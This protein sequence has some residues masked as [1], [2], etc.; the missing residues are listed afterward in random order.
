MGVQT[1]FVHCSNA[2]QAVPQPPQFWTSL[3]RSTQAPE[4]VV[5]PGQHI[6]APPSGPPALAQPE[7]L[8]NP[9]DGTQ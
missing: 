6:D 2:E 3:V 5:K 4:H 8:P 9:Q 7:P 1:L